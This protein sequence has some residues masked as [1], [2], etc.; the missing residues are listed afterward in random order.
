MYFTP[1]GSAN[2]ADRHLVAVV[3]DEVAVGNRCFE[4]T[5]FAAESAA[6]PLRKYARS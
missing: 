3:H 5:S 1:N 6:V 2:V 4:P